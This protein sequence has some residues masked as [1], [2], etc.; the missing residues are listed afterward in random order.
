MAP[1]YEIVCIISGEK[2]SLSESDGIIILNFDTLTNTNVRP[3]C[4]ALGD[5]LFPF[6][7]LG[8]VYEVS[9]C[10]CGLYCL[11][12]IYNIVVVYNLFIHYFF[13]PFLVSSLYSLLPYQD[14]ILAKKSG[15]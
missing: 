1:F 7:T 9:V 14:E 12:A 4:S 10:N 15:S 11:Y 2:V 3:C 6:S 5:T 8:L 13:R